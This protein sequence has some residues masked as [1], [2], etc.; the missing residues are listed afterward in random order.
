[1][2]SIKVKYSRCVTLKVPSKIVAGNILFLF[3][4]FGENKVLTF[5][6]NPLLN[7]KYLWKK[8]KKNLD[9]HLLQFF[10]IGALSVNF[11][12]CMYIHSFIRSFIHSFIHSDTWTPALCLP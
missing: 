10:L 12:C 2:L 3:F 1:M 5:H 7:I 8:K 9:R 11:Y 6:V 4:L